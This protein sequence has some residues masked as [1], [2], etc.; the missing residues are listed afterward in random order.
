MTSLFIYLFFKVFFK[1]QSVFYNI[2]HLQELNKA[3]ESWYEA[4]GHAWSEKSVRGRKIWV[5]GN[6]GLSGELQ[7]SSDGECHTV[8][9]HQVRMC[10]CVLIFRTLTPGCGWNTSR[11]SAVNAWYQGLRWKHTRF[12]F[13]ATETE[14]N[15]PKNAGQASRK[16]HISI[17]CQSLLSGVI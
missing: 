8:A 16:E 14:E 11:T 6:R 5:A 3:Q 7:T 9:W 17:W 12:A 13:Y 1:S 2:H 4:E 15:K 10:V